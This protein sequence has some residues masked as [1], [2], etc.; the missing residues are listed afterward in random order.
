[1]SEQRTP[2]NGAENR[3]SELEITELAFLV[4][5]S[6]I[7]NGLGH[8]HVTLTT[9]SGTGRC[10]VESSTTPLINGALKPHRRLGT[11]R[12]RRISASVCRQMIWAALRVMVTVTER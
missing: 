3:P 11:M 2:G 6:P 4:D 1:M 9:T 7:N 8:E 5:N 10:V 12:Q